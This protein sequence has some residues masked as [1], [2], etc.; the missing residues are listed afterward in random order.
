MHAVMLEEFGGPEK[1]LY[2]TDVPDPEIKEDEVLVATAAASVNPVD[3]KVRESGQMASMMGM[4]LPAIPGRDLSG[5]VRAIGSRVSGV[6]VG[7]RVLAR[8]SGAY[9]SLVKL[10]ATE[11]T[12]IP[13]GMDTVDAAALPLVALTGDQLVREACAVQPG[14]TVLVTGATGSVGRCAVHSA[15]TLGAKVFAGVRKKHV[16]DAK[17]LEVEGVVALDDDDAVDRMGRFDAIA[18]TVGGATATRLLAHVK[19]GGVFGSPVGPVAGSELHPEVRVAQ[20]FAHGA[21]ERLKAFAEDLRDGRFVL[22]IAAR[23]ELAE[24]GKA[25]AFAEKGAPGKVLLL[26]L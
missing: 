18:D 1:L 19:E 4:T 20:M 7:D 24:A 9:A 8:A 23:F 3:W 21:P 25:Q 14:Q 10:S 22:P 15:K 12:H 2:K 5:I 6:A 16:D 17:A 11:I 13:K 26:V